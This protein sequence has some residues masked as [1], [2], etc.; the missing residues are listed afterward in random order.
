MP[1]KA[2]TK[3]DTQYLEGNFAI[4]SKEDLT[5]HLGRTWLSIQNKAHKLGLARPGFYQ[6]E[7][8]KKED[9]ILREVYPKSNQE[10]ILQKLDWDWNAIC[11]RAERIKVQRDLSHIHSMRE[12]DDAYSKEEIEYLKQNFEKGL[13]EDIAE[14]LDR[15]WETIATYARRVL[16]LTRDKELAY[17]NRFNPYEWDEEDIDILKKEYGNKNTNIELIGKKLGKTRK[18]ITNKARKLGIKKER[19]FVSNQWTEGEIRIIKKYYPDGDALDILKMLPRRTWAAVK[20]QACILNLKRNTNILHS[21]RRMK[22]L[23]DEIYPN[24]QRQDNIKPKWLKNPST[25]KPLEL[26]RYYPNLR[27]AFEYNGLQHYEICFGNNEQREQNRLIAQQQRDEAKQKLCANKD[28]TL[29]VVTY[30][31]FLTIEHLKGLINKYTE[32]IFTDNGKDGFMAEIT[33]MHRDLTPIV[34]FSLD[35]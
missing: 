35:D 28:V 18:S 8:T 29:I 1:R 19:Y 31:D 22:Q 5:R 6:R 21:E 14:H 15:R 9:N 30:E 12:R 2:W 4:L 7:W 33:K 13:K 34:G 32:N 17:D 26:D 27:L 23:L 20:A 25:G 10:E 11:R 3:A 16:G 24:E